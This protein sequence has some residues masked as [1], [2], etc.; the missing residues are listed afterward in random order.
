MKEQETAALLS[1]TLTRPARSTGV[2]TKAAMIKKLH[3]ST[4][5]LIVWSHMLVQFG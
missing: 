4:I 2:V 5:T 1:F 3:R